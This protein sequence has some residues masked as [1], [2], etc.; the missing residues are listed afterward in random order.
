MKNRRAQKFVFA[1]SAALLLFVA[2][3]RASA[4]TSPEQSIEATLRK[5]YAEGSDDFR[6]FIKWFDLDGDGTPEAVVHVVGPAVC[7]T[8]GCDTLVFAKRD[9]AYK[10]ISTISVTRPPVIASTRR[11]NGWRNL[12]VFV[13]GG[14]NTRGYYAELKFD[15]SL[16][17]DSPPATKLRGKPRGTVLIKDYKFYTEGKR[18]PPA[19]GK[20]N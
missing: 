5:E 9:D 2:C 11:T 4:Q 7:G 13:A 19:T 14:G 17:P 18:L 15:G 10:L 1:V 16:Y 3:V 8:G 6:Y 12:I 20:T